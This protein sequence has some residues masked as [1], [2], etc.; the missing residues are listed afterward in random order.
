M[1][2]DWRISASSPSTPLVRRVRGTATAAPWRCSRSGRGVP[3][4]RAAESAPVEPD[5]GSA[6]EGMSIRRPTGR[7]PA[8]RV[9]PV[10]NAY[11]SPTLPGSASHA[12]RR[13][14]RS[15]HRGSTG[16]GAEIVR[17]FARE[18]PR[19]VVTYSSSE[20]AAA[21]L[22]AETGADCAVALRADGTEPTR[23]SD[24]RPTPARTAVR[25]CALRSTMP[26]ST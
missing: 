18:R 2:P 19:V 7:P 4:D 15:C 24:S 26:W 20:N 22:V 25:R 23:R 10:I 17:A 21:V 16:L 3:P 9:A 8:S 5:R 6:S 11:R 13:A 14:N 1:E 12:H